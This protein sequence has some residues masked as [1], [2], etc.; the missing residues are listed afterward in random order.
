[1]RFLTFTSGNYT[2]MAKNFIENFKNVLAPCG[3]VLTVVCIDLHAGVNLKDLKYDW[4][5][6]DVRH[7][8]NIKNMGGFNTPTFI[9]IMSFK[10]KFVFEYLQTNDEI[11]FTDCDIVFYK[12]PMDCI[13]EIGKPLIFQRDQDPAYNPGLFCA[14][15]FYVKRT[16][17]T[18]DFMEKWNNEIADKP[19]IA[20]QDTLNDMV[21][22]KRVRWLDVP[23]F[24]PEKFQRGLDAFE[25]NSP[26]TGTDPRGM[27]WWKRDDKVCIHFNFVYGNMDGKIAAMKQLGVW[28]V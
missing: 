9:H 3:H 5:T 1:M 10:P 20:D 16:P 2:D 6:L 23:I 13:R 4:L 28:F 17:D 11:Y 7:M 19:Y 27:G 18:M 25:A 14:G 24:P 21:N 8:H 26:I 22:N 15:N 12:D